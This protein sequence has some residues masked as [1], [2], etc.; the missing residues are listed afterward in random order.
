MKLIR[1]GGDEALMAALREDLAAEEDQANRDEDR[2]QEIS[3][4]ITKLRAEK[5]A[6]ANPTKRRKVIKILK[7]EMER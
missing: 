4:L 5:A 6:I 3:R 7:E 1:R 2:I